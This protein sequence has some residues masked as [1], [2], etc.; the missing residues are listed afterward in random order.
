MGTFVKAIL[1]ASLVLSSTLALAQGPAKGEVL[2]P[3]V[4]HL[5]LPTFEQLDANGDGQIAK[6][7][8]PTGHELN[9]LFSSLDSNSDGQLSR[10][11]Y[12]FYL[13]GEDE[14][15]DEEEDEEA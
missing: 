14:V 5:E 8:V 10:A 15:E 2:D 1:A 3:P 11:E 12:A 7:E 4:G 6:A 9:T 13:D